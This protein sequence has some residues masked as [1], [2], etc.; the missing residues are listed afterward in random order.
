MRDRWFVGFHHL[1][2]SNDLGLFFLLQ[3]K[4]SPNNSRFHNF[5][6]I[7]SSVCSKVY[8]LSEAIFGLVPA[9]IERT[10]SRVFE[11][12]C[13]R[14]FAKNETRENASLVCKNFV[15]FP[16]FLHFSCFPE[17]IFSQNLRGK[18]KFS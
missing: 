5:N 14:I 1:I 18:G 8:L 13:L 15:S 16:S 4:I 7:L 3:T 11:E 12:T 10:S 6:P 17:V 2:H 9:P